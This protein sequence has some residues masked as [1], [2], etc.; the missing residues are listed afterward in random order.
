MEIIALAMIVICLFLISY[1]WIM[2]YYKY[3]DLN[4]LGNAVYK[5]SKKNYDKD[6]KLNKVDLEDL[7]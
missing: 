4:K 5:L 2:L 3:K 7:L 6:D 1:I